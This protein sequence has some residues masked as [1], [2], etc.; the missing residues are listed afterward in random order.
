MSAGT[1]LGQSQLIHHSKTNKQTQYI[2]FSNAREVDTFD[3]PEDDDVYG[4]GAKGS[5]VVF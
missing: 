4:S 2:R 3:S 1:G 5:G